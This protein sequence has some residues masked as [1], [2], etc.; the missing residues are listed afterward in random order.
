MRGVLRRE[1]DHELALCAKVGVQ[2]RYGPSFDERRHRWIVTLRS[3]LG[4]EYTAVSLSPAG[5]VKNA[6]SALG[7]RM[8]NGDIVFEPSVA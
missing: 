8:L 2:R 3:E 7:Y 1:L 6:R 5:A 4:R